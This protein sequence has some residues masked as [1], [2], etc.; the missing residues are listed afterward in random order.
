MPELPEVET[1]RRTLETK[2]IDEEIIDVDI[3]YLPVVENVDSDLFKKSLINEK[4]KEIKRYGKYLIFILEHCSIISHLR[5]EGKFFLKNKEEERN[6]HEHV[7]FTFKSG[8]TLRY[9]DT[10]KFGKMA[11]VNTTN[12]DEIMQYKSLTKLGPEANSEELTVDYLYNKLINKKDP[13][14]TALLNQEILAGIGNIYADEV[15]FLS[16][17]HPLLPCNKLTIEDV[18]NIVKYSKYVLSGAIKAGGTTIRSYTSSLGVTGRFQL[19][20]HVH[21]KENEPCEV[22]GKKIKKIF[23]GGRGTY[24]CEICQKNRRPI[25]IGL[26]GG[27]ATGK[28]TVTNI[29][30]E[31]GY[32]VL[33]SDEIVKNLYEKK[34]V[35]EKIK[36]V[37]G[38]EY[39][40]NNKIDRAKL[41]NLI[42]NNSADKLKLNNIIHPLV[43]KELIVGINNVLSNI[44]FLDIPLLYEAKFEDIC[45]KIIVVNLDFETN[46]LRLMKRDN[47][48]REYAINKINAQMS[49]DEKCRKADFIIDNSKDLC[50]TNMQT[51]KIV[52]MLEDN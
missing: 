44:I 17:L 32:P 23:V 27:I 47:I 38:A 16:R 29:L 50:Y 33:D 15:C 46:V 8:I 42:F 43:K 10:R 4:I 39:I 45:D 37:F 5:M 51:I 40:L 30:I 3:F 12:F 22:C 36:N 20:L 24:F 11:L 25:V 26:T 7:I 2:I 9:H 52:K 28:S 13:I 48:D 21:T 35:I 34:S 18:E 1:V 6:I 14:K 31:M 41:G 49:L 19:E